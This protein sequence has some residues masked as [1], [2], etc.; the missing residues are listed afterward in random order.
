MDSSTDQQEPPNLINLKEN[1]S[2]E[3]IYEEFLN[4]K[5]REDSVN[6]FTPFSKENIDKNYQ[7]T[8]SKEALMQSSNV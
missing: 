6:I 3:K 2:I 4:D 1:G 8:N 5:S 7:T